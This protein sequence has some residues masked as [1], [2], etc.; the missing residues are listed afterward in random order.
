[1]KTGENVI[2]LG[3]IVQILFFGF[4]VAVSVVFHKRMIDNPTSAA[5]ATTVDWRR[6]MLVLY[7][8]SALIMIRCLYRVIEYIEGSDGVLQGHEYFMCILILR[9]CSLSWPFSS[10]F[11]PAKSFPDI[12][13]LT[14]WSSCEER[15]HSG[16]QNRRRAK[17]AFIHSILRFIFHRLIPPSF[18][19][20]S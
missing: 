3:L 1:V 20:E 15:R 9:S 10:L 5:M 14:I 7:F 16:I 13:N 8:A 12:E 19:S 6:Y 11:T 2:I 18:L 17:M 4:F